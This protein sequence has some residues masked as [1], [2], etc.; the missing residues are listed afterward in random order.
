MKIVGIICE[1]NPFHLG[2][3]AQ[4]RNIRQNLGE[5]TA[6]IGVMSGYFVQRGAPAC[7]DPYV[8]ARAAVSCGMDLMLSLPVGK[9]LSSAEGFCRG[10][11]EILDRLGCVEYLSFGCES[12][13][14]ETVLSAAR[15]MEHPDFEERLREKIATGVSYAT[16]KQQM[17]E[18][19]TGIPGIL[20]TPNDILGAEYCRELLR[21]GSNI[22]PLPVHRPGDYHDLRADP[23]NPSATA[24]RKLLDAGG[25][26]PYVPENVR[27]LFRQAEKYSTEYGERA[28]LSRLRSLSE[29]DWEKVPHGSEGLWRKVKK[30]VERETGIAGILEASR[31]KRYPM[32]R[33]NRLLMCAYLGLAPEDLTASPSY[34]RI[35]AMSENGKSVVNRCRRQ[36]DLLLLHPG[37]KP[38]NPADREQE[39]RVSD[40]FSLFARDFSAT[41]PGLETRQRLTFE[42]K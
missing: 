14:A 39:R 7:M 9:S 35:L 32:T 17:V 37:E 22:R 5:D 28:V 20:K 15:A 33:L 42:K 30:A 19:I 31:S 16:A 40:L 6:L 1:Y 24:V 29:A 10:G 2:H 25:W 38:K 36:G 13:N 41:A 18:E 21:R 3:L 4:I 23:E 27:G 11:V 34:V 12:P 8:R 26:E